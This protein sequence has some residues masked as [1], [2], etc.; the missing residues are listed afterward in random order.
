MGD[1]QN[2]EHAEREREPGGGQAVK[3]ADQES[4]NELLGEDHSKRRKE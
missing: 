1:V 4:E 3:A 2:P